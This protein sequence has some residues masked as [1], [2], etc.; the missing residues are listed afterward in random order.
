MTPAARVA[1]AIECLDAIL[2]GAPAERV[3]TR[4]ARG[5]RFAGSKDRAAIRDHVFDALRCRRSFAALGGGE[6]GRGLMLGALHA[7]GTPAETVFTGERH[8]PA[9]PSP[10]ERAFRPPAMDALPETVRLDCPDWLAPELRASLGRDFAPVMAAL[11]AR[12]PVHLRVNLRRTGREAAARRL[13]DEGITTRPHPLSPTALEVM[14]GARRVRG[15]GAF[16]DGWIELQDA[17]SQAVC[18]A[19]P[20]P[21]GARVLDL[22]AGGGGK[23][24][25]LAGRARARFFAHDAAPRRMADLPARAARAGVEVERLD[26]V[27]LATAAPF[28]LVVADVPC[29]GSGAWRRAPEGKWRLDAPALARLTATQ[30]AILDHA[31]ALTA[32]GGVLAYV[33]CSLLGVENGARVGAFLTRHPGWRQRLSRALTPLEGGD[34]FFV[35]LLTRDSQAVQPP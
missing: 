24:L 30:D 1:A 26:T 15:S 8:A 31:A 34:G 29:S 9:A 14:A 35:T 16:A 25:A 6:T 19:I 18:D 33:T 12:A 7:A 21:G 20:V 10:A 17:A 23:T 4:W 22:C 11:R 2:D 27:A 32:Q 3:L 5:H 13:A 28:D